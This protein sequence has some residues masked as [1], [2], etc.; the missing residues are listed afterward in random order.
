MVDPNCDITSDDARRLSSGSEQILENAKIFPTLDGA[1]ADLHRVMAT[2]IRPRSMSQIVVSPKE[3]ARIAIQSDAD[4]AASGGEVLRSGIVFGRERS[5][6]TNEEVAMADSIVSI[7]TFKHFSSL[8]LAQAVNIVCFEVWKQHAEKRGGVASPPDV[9]LHPRDGERM[10][11][12]EE[13]DVLLERLETG[14]TERQYQPDLS[15]RELCYRNIR[16]VFQRTLMTKQEIDLLHGVL[17][18]IM[19]APTVTDADAPVSGGCID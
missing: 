16:N 1:V 19:K 9:W 15:R 12:R 4:I 18:S 5:G 11:R 2:T 14:L 10:A 6:L 13:L 3:A 7:P 8:N 17:S